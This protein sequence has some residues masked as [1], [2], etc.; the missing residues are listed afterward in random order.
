MK[1]KVKEMK[2]LFQAA[3]VCVL[4][5][6]MI[7]CPTM[8]RA[9]VIEADAE[10]LNVGDALPTYRVGDTLRVLGTEQLSAAGWS[11]LT[12]AEQNF[13][14]ELDNGQTSIPAKA[15]QNARLTSLTAKDV[16]TVGESAFSA[17]LLASVEL[18]V[19]V[20]IG[21]AAFSTTEL[22]E[23]SLPLA[24]E[25]GE[26]AFSNCVA[27]TKADLPVATTVGQMAFNGD[28]KLASVTLPLATAVGLRAFY[29]DVSLTEISLPRAATVGNE[30][31][32]GCSALANATLPAVT[33]IGDRAFENCTALSHLYLDGAD[34]T[35]GADAFKGVPALTIH[36][37]KNKTLKGTYPAGYR[38]DYP[39]ESGSSGGGCDAGIP[40]MALLALALFAFGRKNGLGG[41]GYEK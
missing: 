37:D 24:K 8:A 39:A 13:V 10:S 36:V 22:T 2:R 41:F 1:G 28:S 33:K 9:E 25:I 11:A 29:G 3:A 6:G 19:A 30:A 23:I 27:L 18:P 34:P 4:A 17:S 5:A 26:R 7:F 14:L 38:L 15:M 16:T 32:D 12:S 35:T 21:D 31:F 20:T 40:G